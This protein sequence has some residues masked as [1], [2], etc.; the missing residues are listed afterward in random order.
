MLMQCERNANAMRIQCALYA[1]RMLTNNQYTNS[2][3]TPETQSQKHV[4]KANL[5]VNPSYYVVLPATT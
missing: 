3:K 2:H 4:M 1:F 5:N